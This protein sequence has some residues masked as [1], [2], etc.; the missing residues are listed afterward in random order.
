MAALDFSLLGLNQPS[1]AERFYQGQ[2]EAQR[3]ALAQ[4]QLLHAQQQ[5]ALA[6][7]QM[8]EY[9]R[10]RTA[11]EG[12]RNYFAQAQTRGASLTSPEFVQGLYGVSPEKG[13]AYEKTVAERQKAVTEEAARRAKLMLDKT[14]MYKDALVDVNTPQDAA[15]WLQT[16][17]ADP[18]M[19]GSPVTKRPIMEV[20]KSI[21]TDPTAFGEWK[22][23]TALGMKDFFEKNKPQYFQ[24][25][26]GG[27][28]QITAVPGLLPGPATVVSGSTFAKTATPG[29]LLV[30]QRARERLAQ[31]TAAGTLTPA[32]LDLA[33]NLYLQTGQ[34]PQGM[35]TKASQ[36]RTQVMNRATELQ[37]GKPPAEAASD[38][39]GAKQTQA[40][41]ASTVKA[42]SSGLEAR[43]VRS[44]NTAIDH[45]D[46]MSKLATALDNGDI[47]AFN[48]VGQGFASQ[49][50]SA[51]PTN[52]DTAKSVVGG[53]VAKA[54]AGSSMALKDRE[55]IRDSISRA[56]SPAQLA[57][58]VNTLQQ[59]L[60]GQLKSLELQY[61]TG[62]KRKDFS[63]K[64]TP[65]AK[66]VVS[67]LGGAAPAAG[68]FSAQDQQ[69]LE[70]AKS[71]PNDPRAAQI[72]QRLGVQ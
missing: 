63:E 22:T 39:I 65:A 20:V 60:G 62:T 2:Q 51:A 27:T 25:N 57:G 43:N 54:L 7:Q 1:I 50:G 32:S 38:I 17:V 36:M 72:K 70:W 28:T 67:R 66:A 24:Q 45:L 56:N 3:N 34:L 61:E 48:A 21:P 14:Q 5:N 12:V 18:D 41:A 30:D 64:L 42:F 6:Q 31:E 26:L 4:Q 44:F 9:Q 55:E 52:F 29:E 23:K 15:R 37:G 8:A 11:E 10:A 59:L 69:A 68:A 46:T 19:A 33:A 35:G 16:Q 13:M 58:A 49:T 71:N 47:K 40:A 53:E